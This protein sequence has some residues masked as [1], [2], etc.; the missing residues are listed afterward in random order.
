M[1]IK[2]FLL[3]IILLV[4]LTIMLIADYFPELPTSDWFPVSALLW[5]MLAMFLIS[6]VVKDKAPDRLN[7]VKWRLSLLLYMIV[8]LALLTLLGGHSSVGISFDNSFLWIVIFAGLL[9][10][11]LEWKK[12]KRSKE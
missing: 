10:V 11:Y 5:L 12:V 6:F 2:K 3:E 7:K 9:E 4:L 1:I 8:L